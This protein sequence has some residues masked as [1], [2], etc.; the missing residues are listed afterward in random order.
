MFMMD[1]NPTAAIDSVGGLAARFKPAIDRLAGGRIQPPFRHAEDAVR[2][3]EETGFSQVSLHDPATHPAGSTSRG[4]WMAVVEGW[5]NPA[6]GG[7]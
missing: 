6:A 5:V 1:V 3:F 2:L 4:G 7:V